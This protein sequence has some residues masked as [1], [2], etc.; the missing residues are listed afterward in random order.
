LPDLQYLG[1]LPSAEALR[2]MSG[3]TVGV[4]P[5]HDVRES[6]Y[7]QAVTGIEYLALGKPI[8]AT[9]LPG[10]RALVDH[11]VNGMLVPPG[12]AEAMAQ[13]IEEIVTNPGLAKQMGEASMK[14]AEAFDAPLIRKEVI[15][16]LL[17]S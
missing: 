4:I 14:K 2:T 13:A 15:R 9:D 17:D 11:Y 10:A 6:A 12:D 16:V 3:V 8:V 7:I 5:F 1:V